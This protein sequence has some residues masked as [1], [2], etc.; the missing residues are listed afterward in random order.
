M[1]TLDIGHI[2]VWLNLMFPE[3]VVQIFRLSVQMQKV[4]NEYQNSTL[5]VK[6]L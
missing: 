2:N 1:R 3:D 4:P 5:V 6:S